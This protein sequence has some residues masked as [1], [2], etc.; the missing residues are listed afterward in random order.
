[1]IKAID[2]G[3]F[4][5]AFQIVIC[6]AFLILIMNPAEPKDIQAEESCWEYKHIEEHVIPLHKHKKSCKVFDVSQSIKFKQ[7]S[8]DSKRQM[9]YIF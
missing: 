3:V 7:E 1:M 9:C 2:A 8:R 6:S 4:V 5:I